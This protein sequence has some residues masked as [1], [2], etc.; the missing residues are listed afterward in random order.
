M[1]L[2]PTPRY[3]HRLGRMPVRIQELAEDKLALMVADPRHPSLHL[4]LVKG[5]RGIWEMRVT[6]SY[7]ILLRFEGD[8]ANLLTIGSHDI[9]DRF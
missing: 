5:A 1:E 2:H 7:R 6:I 4:K 8:V 9:I 3:L